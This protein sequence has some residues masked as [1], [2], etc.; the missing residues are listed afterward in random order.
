MVTIR[1]SPKHDAFEAAFYRAL[2]AW[3][4]ESTPEDEF[5]WAPPHDWKT[6]ILSALFAC[7]A[8]KIARNQRGFRRMSEVL[9]EVFSEKS[10]HS[11][12]KKAPSTAETRLA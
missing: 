4:D 7:R 10:T 9:R 3:P 11:P 6:K 5:A 12:A 1:L 8:L 2:L